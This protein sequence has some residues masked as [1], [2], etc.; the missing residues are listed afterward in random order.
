M[1][2]LLVTMKDGSSK[3]L[4]ERR[5]KQTVTKFGENI[6]KLGIVAAVAIIP[7]SNTAA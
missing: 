4:C 2:T 6:K 1:F 3:R 5:S 7:A